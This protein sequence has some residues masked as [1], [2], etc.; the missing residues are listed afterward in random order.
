M[1]EAAEL[2]QR[3]DEATYK[4]K[5]PGLREQLL[6]AQMQVLSTARFPVIIVLGGVAGGGKS[7]TV[8]TLTEWMDPRFIEVHAAGSPSDEE[9]ERPP[10]WRFWRRLPP[11]GKIGI[12]LSS[13]YLDALDERVLG[14]GSES[15]FL[16]A[17][18]QSRRFERML[19]D[20]G[21]LVLKFW[22]H[23]S[24]K[25]Q[26]HRLDEL[27][28]DK[29]TRYR[30]R[31][32]DWK[33][34][35][36]YDDYRSASARA[37]SETDASH[38]PWLVL[39]G[40]DRRYRH[41][42][43]GE[44]LLSAMQQR[45]GVTEQAQPPVAAPSID[46]TPIIRGLDLTLALDKDAYDAKLEKQQRRLAVLTQRRRF[47]RLSPVLVFEGVDAAGKGGAIR[48][49]TQALDARLYDVHPIGAPT[50]EEKRQPYLWRFWRSL[51]RDGKFAI[52]DRS[53]YGRV[54]VERVEGFATEGEWRRA[55]AEINDFE[56]QLARAGNVVV[57]FWLQISKEEQ[58]RRFHER[59]EVAFKRFK[60]TPD[61]WR[62]RE[63]WDAHERAASDM[64]ERTSTEHAPW[65][66]VAAEDKRYARVKI[67]TT[68][69]DAIERAEDGA[70]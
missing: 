57:K 51:P 35:E 33:Q 16:S 45:L 4:E 59:E 55:Y 5:L 29:K 21:A 37:L 28:A 39:E 17:L 54:L 69:A 62:N 34:L 25:A 47:A 9:L 40:A 68:I 56:S 48:R 11:R 60:I 42:S 65:T 63:K 58:L 22:Y 67:L 12:F 32:E 13:W 49:V 70:V 53:W 1:F 19:A 50:D 18:S 24:K 26:R 41:F 23:L 8:K 66:L 38:A 61:D 64:I 43:T 14:K 27:W 31:G 46:R 7:E 15:D 3:L 30:A 52:Y 10:M 20:E 6:A 44:A 36:R 2:G